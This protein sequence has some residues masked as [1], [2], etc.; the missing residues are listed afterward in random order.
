VSDLVRT[1]PDDAELVYGLLP[2][3]YRARDSRG[4][5]RAFLELFGR[6][7][8]RLRGN[9]EQLWRDFFVDSCQEWVLPYLADLVGTTILPNRGAE[10]RADVKKT[11]GWRRR[12]GTLDGL[13][14]IAA[15]IADRGAHAVEMFERLVW[16]QHL[17]HR[18]PRATHAIDLAQ[19]SALS[20]LATPFDLSCRSL[21]LR[22]GGPGTGLHQPRT[23]AVF[24]QALLSYRC[25]G[26]DVAAAGGGRYRL[27]PLGLDHPLYAGGER[28][29]G[30]EGTAVDPARRPDACFPHAD[31]TP[32]RGRDFQDD[33][34]AYFGQPFGFTLYEDGIAVAATRATL[35]SRSTAPG[36]EMA[37]LAAQRGLVC[38]DPSRFGAGQ[39]FAIEAVR[40]AARTV[41][42]EGAPVPVVPSPTRAFANQF[43]VGP[44]QAA[45]DT[46]GFAYT[47]GATFEPGAP[48]FHH[49]VLLL[50]IARLG[51]SATFP[52]CEVITRN[53]RGAALLVYLPALAGLGPGQRVHLYVADDGTTYFARATHG[54]GAVDL[55]PDSALFGAYLGR[56]L[57]R[58]A[59]GQARPQPG[60]RPVTHRQAVYR[61]LCCWDQPLQHALAPGQ[62]A[63]DPQRGRALF[64]AGEAPAGELTADF[65]FART[66]E[67]GAGPF[68]RADRR[69][70]T[71]TVS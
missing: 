6:E 43:V 55:N 46:N 23:L 42:V 47:K 32:I 53:E 44:T 3:L 67:V 21:D 31:H 16:S 69:A 70:A 60:V 45:L 27:H 63:F 15:T 48:G 30:C 19:G 34:L 52:E 36:L 49:P 41:L 9:T 25:K 65:R 51:T 28:A 14:E 17:D 62:V 71:L 40:L 13:T 68:A 33:P 29:G 18:R 20:R 7:L 39:R 24:L 11:V 57:A 26:S 54:P 12:K 64:P 35:P 8:G 61:D 38:A 5:L 10:N 22:P 37:E 4:E 56:H 66:G 50:R 2:A 1:T 58:E 59:R